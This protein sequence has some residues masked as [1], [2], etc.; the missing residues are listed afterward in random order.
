[1]SGTLLIRLKGLGDIVHLLPAMRMLRET[2]PDEPLGFLCQKPF[3]A[4]VPPDLGVTLFQLPPHASFAE[5][6]SLVRRLR[7]QRY[8]RL[9]DLFGNPR[10][11]LISL[12]SGIPFR[13]GFDYRVRRLAYHATFAP[14]DPN[15]HLTHLFGQFLE[16]FGCGGP[17]GHPR[18]SWAAAD[19]ARAVSL[20]RGLDRPL[21]GINPHTTYPSKA[22]PLGHYR[23]LADRWHAATGSRVLVF[24]GPGEEAT[25]RALVADLGP[26]RACT[27]PAL[28]IP[29]FVALL[30]RTD[31]FVTADTG[32]MNIAW[33]LGVPTVALFGPTTRRAVAPRGDQ[34]LVLHHPDLAC[35]ECHK[36]VCPDG[37]CMRELTPDQVWD[38]IWAKFGA[39]VESW[40]EAAGR[41]VPQPGER[42]TAV[43]R[44]PRGPTEAPPT[45]G[46][47][48]RAVFLDRDGTL[49]PDPGYI[50]RPEDFA[51]FPGVGKELRRLREKGFLLVVVTNQS[52]VARGKFT[53]ETLAAIHA[54]MT[55]SLGEDG[56]APDA[57]YVCPHHPGYPR[58]GRP[59][60]CLCRKPAPGLVL[61]A[62]EEMGIDLAGSFVVGDRVKDAQMG[63]NAGVRPVLVA[64]PGVVFPDLPGVAVATSFGGAVDWI[65]SQP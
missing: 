13:A 34:H 7:R 50:S 11:A 59:N 51:L 1:M 30:A 23:A 33:A 5:T 9:F 17:L 49:N 16:H 22:W 46:V 42:G 45:G 60:L 63:I 35:L 8:D 57:I 55:A 36:E 4:I 6:L 41:L 52:G 15:R 39:T 19:E 10:T 43:G 48:R 24:W 31:L 47:R 58:T 64:Q 25:A 14:P 37:A 29:E 28:T 12:L 26:A 61:R 27:H 62:A 40:T 18:L 44:G 53:P 54:R 20:V 21:L 32:P 38:Q 3:G 56:A 2:R 65:L